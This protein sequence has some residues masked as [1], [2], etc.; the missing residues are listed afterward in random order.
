[1]CRP[2]RKQVSYQEHKEQQKKIRKAQRAVEESE[3]KIAKY[4]NR[5]KELDRLLMDPA[6]AADMEKVTEYTGTKALLDK[7]NEHWMEL[8]MTLEE[9]MN[10]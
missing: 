1:M 4:E 7:E 2:W 6:N 10:Q 5:L 3:S 9:L 8:S